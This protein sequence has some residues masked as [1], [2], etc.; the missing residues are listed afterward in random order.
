MLDPDNIPYHGAAHKSNNSGELTAIGE[1]LEWIH[2]QPPDPA[3]TTKYARTATTGS[4][5]WTSCPGGTALASALGDSSNRCTINLHKA[6]EQGT[7]Y[8]SERLKHIGLTI[9]G[10][11]GATVMRTN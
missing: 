3:P 2:L 10:T 5:R 8:S 1:D 7:S 4:M 6:E 9:R 11:V